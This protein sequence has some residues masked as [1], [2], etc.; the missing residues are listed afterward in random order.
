[1]AERF[2]G[3]DRQAKKASTGI[4]SGPILLVLKQNGPRFGFPNFLE[5]RRWIKGSV[6]DDFHGHLSCVRSVPPS[7]QA[8]LQFH[9]WNEKMK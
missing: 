7:L 1:M 8:I 9:G 4:A 6:C 2:A 5:H 3:L